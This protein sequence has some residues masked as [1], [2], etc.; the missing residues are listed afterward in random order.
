MVNNVNVLCLDLAGLSRFERR[1]LFLHLEYRLSPFDLA[2]VFQV[3]DM[4][5][6]KTLRSARR[7]YQ[8]CKERVVWSA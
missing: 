3:D 7:K 6:H 1:L 4:T 2:E 8:H 5:V